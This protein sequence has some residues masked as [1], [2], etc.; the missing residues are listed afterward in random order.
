MIAEPPTRRRVVL[1]GLLGTAMLSGC[2]WTDLTTRK[3]VDPEAADRARLTR[4]R[5]LSSALKA[6]IDAAVADD[7]LTS[8]AFARFASLHT[9]QIAEFARAASIPTVK[10]L[11][12][13]STSNLTAT[14]VRRRE[15]AL[16]QALRGLALDAQ[17]G[18]V[19]ALLASAAA[20]IDEALSR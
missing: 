2:S 5:D 18:T 20:G 16:A 15:Q 10:P 11:P 13:L 4:A 17:R 19:A 1:G 7:P 6:E 9:Q 8:A 12:A 14:L 3:V